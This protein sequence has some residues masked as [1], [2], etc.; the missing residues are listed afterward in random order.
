M[1]HARMEAGN[2]PLNRNGSIAACLH[3]NSAV[4]LH[5]V[6]KGNGTSTTSL[7]DGWRNGGSQYFSPAAELVSDFV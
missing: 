2:R 6:E 1:K 4:S 3:A 5:S 7:A